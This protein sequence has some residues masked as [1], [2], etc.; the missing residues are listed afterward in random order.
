MFVS[1]LI[2]FLVSN[3]YYQMK[4]K[5]YNDHKITQ[6]TKN[7]VTFCEGNS[8]MNVD[9]YLDHISQL[10]YQIALFDERKQSTYYGKPFQLNNLLSSN[11][12]QV[13][14]GKIYHGIQQFPKG[15]F[16]TGFFDDELRNTIGVPID[17]NGKRKALFLRPNIEYQFGEMRIFFAVLVALTIGLS[18]LFVLIGTYYVVKPIKNLTSATK[19]VAQGEYDL[20]LQVHRKDEI[21]KLARYF[22]QM[23]QSVKS[24]D[25]MRQEFVSNVSHEIQ[26]PL[27]SIQGFSKTL[28]TENLTSEQE[29]QYLAIIEKESHRLSLLSKQLLTLAS[30]DKESGLMEKTLFDLAEQIK[31]VI[32]M[33]EWQWR[34]KDLAIEMELPSTM[35]KADSRLLHQVWTNLITN[36]V[37]FT[38]PEGTISVKIYHLNQN[39][40]Q[41]MIEDTGIGIPD[42]S[43]PHIFERFYKVD[44]SRKRNEHGTGLGLSI[45]KKIVEM[46]GGSIRVTSQEGKG[47]KFLI[48]L[49]MK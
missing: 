27:A 47:T 15:A 6:M 49:P 38:E 18:V 10:G 11:I 32:F 21:G 37:K 23:A 35:I 8:E 40:V 1:G 33:S 16:V 34:E 30:L 45:V 25:E 39:E 41:V 14:N 20:H 9:Q 24:L 44:Q 4:L 28:Q 26:S 42:Q 36:S 3:V 43:L 2:A 48:Q 5:S 17:I 13:M 12:D 22:T 7:I 46:H 19:L 31:Q 29:K